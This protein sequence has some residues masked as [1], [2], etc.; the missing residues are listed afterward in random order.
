MSDSQERS[1]QEQEARLLSAAQSGDRAAME[2]LLSMHQDRIYRTA[3]SYLGGNEEGATEVAQDVLISVARNLAGFRGDSRLTTWLY[4]MTVNY[5][6]N[7]LA[8]R[9]RRTARFVS[10]DPTAAGDEDAPPVIQAADPRGNTRDRAAA[11][12]MQSIL[13]QRI[14][15]L[16][17][18]FRTVMILRFVEDQSY[19]E[20]GETLS[21]PV[22]TVK[23]RINRGRAELRRLMADVLP[24]GESHE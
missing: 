22:G 21:I 1:E 15:Q 3:L 6:K 9:Q 4:R 2:R 17:E 23:S 12:E 5:A 24:G 18:D 13:Q 8:A 10:L 20:I 11:S 7:Y 16:P 19:E 14:A